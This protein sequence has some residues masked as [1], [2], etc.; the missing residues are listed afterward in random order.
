V[1]RTIAFMRAIN[2]GGHTVRMTDLQGLIEGLGL[3]HVETFLASGNV[4]F[5]TPDQ[6]ASVLEDLIENKLHSALGYE[7]AVFLRTEQEVRL[8]TAYQPFSQSELD[9]SAAFNVAFVKE[10]LGEDATQ[11]LM[12]LITSIDRFHNHQREIYWICKM[13]QSESTF[14][15]SVL[16]KTIGR[17]STLRGINT[18]RKLALKY[19]AV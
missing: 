13:K 19:P 11:K 10:P 3:A 7:V 14:S 9:S 15:N 4:I 8:I 18:L 17:P 6:D 2:V 16:E 12:A 1:D 5:E